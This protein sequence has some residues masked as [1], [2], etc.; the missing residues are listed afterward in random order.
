MAVTQMDDAI[1]LSA[2]LFLINSKRLFAKLVSK[3][4]AEDFKF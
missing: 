2:A 1:I 4:L 3:N